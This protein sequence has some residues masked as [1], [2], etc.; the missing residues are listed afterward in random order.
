ME[1]LDQSIALWVE[2]GGADVLD[3]Q[4]PNAASHSLEV[5]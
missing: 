3:A 2:S 1:V 5:N 4:P